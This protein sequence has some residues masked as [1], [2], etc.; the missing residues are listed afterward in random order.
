MSLFSQYC[1]Y[2]QYSTRLGSSFNRVSHYAAYWGKLTHLEAKCCRTLVVFTNINTTNSRGV[3]RILPEVRT[4]FQIL[5]PTTPKSQI[6]FRWLDLRRGSVVSIFGVYEM[7]TKSYFFLSPFSVHWLQHLRNNRC[8]VIICDRFLIM[9]SRA[10]WVDWENRPR[11]KQRV[12]S[13][14]P[15]CYLLAIFPPFPV[16]PMNHALLWKPCWQSGVGKKQSFI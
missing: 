15:A 7:T 1:D 16:R 10:N 12:R 14:Y 11:W 4:I 6:F 8:K 2:Y 3:A 13:Y 5:P 9:I